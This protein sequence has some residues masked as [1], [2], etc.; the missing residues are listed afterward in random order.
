M[1]K[2][3]LGNNI[4]EKLIGSVPSIS[5]FCTILRILRESMKDNK[6]KITVKTIFGLE[7]VLVEELKELGYPKVTKLNRAVQLEGKW[8]D[9]YM[10][11][12]HLRCAIAVLVEVKQFKIK[13][14]KDVYTQAMK[15]DW[16]SYFDIDKSFAVK[17]AVFSDLFNH[18]QFPFLLVKDA[19]C[20]VFRDKEGDRPNV[21]VKRPQVLFD[22]YINRN[23]VTVS[24]NTSGAPLFQ[25]GYREEVGLAPLNEVVAAG[26]IRLSGWDK[27]S[28]FIDPFCGSG[29]LLIEA[30]LYAANIPSQIE[31]QHYAFK[32][33]KGYQEDVWDE[34]YN[35][36]NQRVRELPCRIIGSDISAE[37]VTKTRRNLRSF[38]VGRFVETEVNAFDELTIDYEPGVM[39]SNPPYGE[40]MGEEIEEMYQKLGDWMKDQLDGFDSWILSS[41]IEAFK[42][43]GLRPSRKIKAFNG[44]LECSFRKYEMY[45]GSKKGKYMSP[46][47]SP[48]EK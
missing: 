45:K 44:D 43:L 24:L 1:N 22:V 32:N 31:R 23:N 14:E 17:G 11:N 6:L 35:S 5:F 39:I 15:I 3:G 38:S 4:K 13:T 20:D 28:T 16:P 25:R 21:N 37:M 27:K 41:N 2:L 18:T 46:E 12:F 8:K 29:T 19:I 40:R 48:E 9:V 47:D 7:D 34:I 26:L 33:F 42:M 30:A 36:V 10:L